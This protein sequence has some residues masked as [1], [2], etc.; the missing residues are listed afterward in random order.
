MPCRA[1][2]GPSSEGPR[3]RGDGHVAGALDEIPKPVIVALLRAAVVVMGMII[4]RS[5]T[6]LNSSRTVQASAGATTTRA[7]KCG[8]PVRTA[9]RSIRLDASAKWTVVAHDSNHTRG[10]G[11][12]PP[13][14]RVSREAEA[15]RTVVETA[16]VDSVMRCL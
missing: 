11:D 4:G 6:P 14:S 7:G 5:L 2:H 9:P 16:R 15:F 1:T 13:L 3:I 12:S 10:R 8:M